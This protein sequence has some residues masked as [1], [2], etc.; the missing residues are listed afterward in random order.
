MAGLS[1]IDFVVCAA[2]LLGITGLGVFFY[3]KGE[4]TSKEFFLAS[5][6]MGWLPVGL[7]LM[8]T[9]T[10]G[11]G[12]IGQPAGLVKYGMVMIWA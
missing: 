8:A 5:R 1:T 12:F 9:L 7:S 11:I 4:K 3:F 10:S 2:Y 6:S